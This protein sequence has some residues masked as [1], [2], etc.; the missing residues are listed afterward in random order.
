MMPEMSPNEKSPTRLTGRQI[1]IVGPR[2][3]QNELMAFFLEQ[4]TGVE[5]TVKE[6]LSHVNATDDSGSSPP[7]LVLVECFEKDPNICLGRLEKVDKAILSGHMLAIFN[8]PPDQGVEEKAVALGVRGVFYDN[9][10]IEQFSKGIGAVFDGEL[11]VSREI[12]TRYVMRDRQQG[13]V[14]RQEETVLT[15]REIEIL[16]MISAGEKNEKIAEKL[17][18]SPNTVKTHIY[19]IFKKIDVP[20]RLQAAL[21]AAK[22]L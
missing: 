8:V 19:N 16:T 13:G 11:W 21:W 4:H 17:C 1:Y 7:K 3:L 6:E 22:N 14:S 18:I 20:N 5:C 15:T 9:D 10:P 12:L 2:R